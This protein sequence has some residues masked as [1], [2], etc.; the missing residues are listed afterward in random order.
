[1]STKEGNILQIVWRYSRIILINLGIFVVIFICTS[2]L[3]YIL[4]ILPHGFSQQRL[5]QVETILYWTTVT[6]MLIFIPFTMIE[7]IIEKIKELTE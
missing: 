4:H 3:D 7:I 1:M 6:P 2:I 5:I